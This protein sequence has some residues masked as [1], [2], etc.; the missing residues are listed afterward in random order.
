MQISN[1]LDNIWGVGRYVESGLTRLILK[2]ILQLGPQ[3]LLWSWSYISSTFDL[4]LGKTNQIATVFF[5]FPAIA[6][7]VSKFEK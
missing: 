6:N 5:K 3:I 1:K 4:I 7:S 2:C